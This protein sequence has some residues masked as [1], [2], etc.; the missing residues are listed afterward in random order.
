MLETLRMRSNRLCLC[1]PPRRGD[2]PIPKNRRHEALRKSRSKQVVCS[3]PTDLVEVFIREQAQ[4][5]THEVL[6]G[7]HLLALH[8]LRGVFVE[9]VAKLFGRSPLEVRRSLEWKTKISEN[10][11]KNLE[12]LQSPDN[13]L[14]TRIENFLRTP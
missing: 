4:E 11:T 7:H 9:D 13:L 10:V 6:A 5:A 14:R 1:R 3:N 2:K 8:L 12:K